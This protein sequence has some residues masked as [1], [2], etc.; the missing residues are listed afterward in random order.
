VSVEKWAAEN[1]RC[2]KNN[3]FFYSAVIAALFPGWLLY[4]GQHTKQYRE[5]TG[6][7]YLK[8]VDGRVFDPTAAQFS[9][10]LLVQSRN[11]VRVRENLD[12]VMADSLF[13]TLPVSD[14]ARIQAFHSSPEPGILG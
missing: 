3:C 7:F 12:V 2:P 1:V 10:G 8:H 14:Q 6:H 5:D 9:G 13:A 4:K 11:P